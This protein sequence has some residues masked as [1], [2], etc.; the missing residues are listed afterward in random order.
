MNRQLSLKNN[1]CSRT[2]TNRKVC[3]PERKKE[4]KKNNPVLY[5]PGSQSTKH[6]GR[7]IVII[8]IKE[9]KNNAKLY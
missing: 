3:L 6:Q 9:R 5:L 8:V 1:P 2:N 4:R 7:P